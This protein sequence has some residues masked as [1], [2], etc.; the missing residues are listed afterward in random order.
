M[1]AN[2]IFIF[3]FPFPFIVVVAAASAND[4]VGEQVHVGA[5]AAFHLHLLDVLPGGF[6]GAH[7]CWSKVSHTVLAH[8][9]CWARDGTHFVVALRIQSRAIR[10][11]LGSQ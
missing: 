5:E 1:P 8:L 11:V 10:I 9:V 7:M 6:C 3:L 4:G 2:S